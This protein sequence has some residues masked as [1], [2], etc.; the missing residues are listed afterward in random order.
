MVETDALGNITSEGIVEPPK[1]GKNI[2][3]SIDGKIQKA[4]YKSMLDISEMASY[5]GGSA[6]IL[7]IH[8]GEIIALSNFP[9]YDSTILSDGSDSLKIKK[10][11]SDKNNPFLN[12]AIDG[13][14]TPGSIVKPFIA[15]G[16]LDR[17][18]ID[19]NKTILSTGS[20]SIPNPYD[21]TKFSIF[22]DWRPQGHVD[23]RK[24]L[25]VSSNVYFYEVGGGFEKQKGLG[26]YG[27][28][29]YMN[30]FGFGTTTGINFYGEQNGVIPDPE[31]KKSVFNGEVWRLGDTY[32]TAIGQY[33]MQITPIQA[34]RAISALANGGNLLVP[35]FEIGKT[36]I[37]SA[38]IS[39]DPSYYKIV[40]EGMR[41]SVTEGTSQAINLPF[42]KIASKTGT[43][44]IGINKDQVNSW[45]IGFWPYDNPHYAF[46]VVMEKGSKNNQFGSV[47]VWQQFFNWL[48]IYDNGYLK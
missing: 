5:K 15:M 44:Q 9:E 29:Q 17:K 41:D 40:L 16:V 4:L 11:L 38:R 31:W 45:T 14:Y 48:N 27:I 32:N 23:L 12:R 13:L 36:P 24:A 26:I 19:P 8:T 43:A 10:W 39:L 3:I 20:I 7:D 42:V 34:V 18:I 33:G 22:Y 21:P 30:M 2:T 25:A 47:L 35:T 6:I 1:S 37:V 46:V 28:K